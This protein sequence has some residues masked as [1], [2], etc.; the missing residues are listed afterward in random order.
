MA[1][2]NRPSDRKEAAKTGHRP[3]TA[4]SSVRGSAGSSRPA[5]GPLTARAP[6]ASKRSRDVIEQI[7][8]DRRDAIRELANR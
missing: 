3:S 8:I 1:R 4:K 7:S 6:R 5:E 2:P